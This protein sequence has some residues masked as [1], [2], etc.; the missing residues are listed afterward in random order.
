MSFIK[1]ENGLEYFDE[2]IGQGKEVGKKAPAIEV[3]YTGWL[4]N[5]DGSKGAKF[6]SSL[7]RNEPLVFPLGAGYVIKGWEEGIP[8]MKEGGKRTLRIPYNLGYGMHG[9]GDVIPPLADL[10]FEIE[11][12]K[13]RS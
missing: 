13:I 2:V 7:D 11:L 9:A 10:I 6:D 4:L 3:H 12:L 5:A 1:M 8:G